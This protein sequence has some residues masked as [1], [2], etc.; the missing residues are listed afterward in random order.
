[1]DARAV[2]APYLQLAGIGKTFGSGDRQVQALGRVDLDVAEGE[3]LAIVG[4]N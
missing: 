1:M 4:A 3:F 2:P